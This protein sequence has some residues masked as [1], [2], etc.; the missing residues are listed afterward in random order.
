M[1][2][3]NTTFVTEFILMGLSSRRKT[4]ILLFVVF[5]LMYLATIVVNLLII[6]LVRADPCLHRPMYFFLTHLSGL[7]ICF[8]T[9]TMPQML[10]HLITGNGAIS[11]TR[12]AAQ[13]YATTCL[14]CTEYLLLGA[15]AYD[16]CL[17][18]YNPLAY[19]AVMSR[20]RQWQL[21]SSSWAAGFLL[22]S[23]NVTG[24]ISL[25][26]CG[27]NRINHFF[28]EQ[29]VVFKYTCK[30]ARYTE[31]IILMV[32]TLILVGPFFVILTSYGLILYSVFW[33][34]SRVGWRKALSTCTSHLVV[35][36]LFYST[37]IFMYVRPGVDAVIDRDKQTAILYIVVTPMLNPI[38]YSLRNKEIHR[39]VVK[40]LRR[41]GLGQK[42]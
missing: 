30:E 41:P 6:I 37:L 9:T 16:R 8:V 26:F 3:E 35:V 18:I 15:M 36:T 1:R 31:P 20:K 42:N 29:P 28:C 40:V 21:T 5:F 27:S 38:I 7:E 10:A 25:P 14:G 17:A 11:F 2:P 34:P 32:S 4:Q 19:A 22:A 39:A 23:L 33:M 24:T 13:M 12:C